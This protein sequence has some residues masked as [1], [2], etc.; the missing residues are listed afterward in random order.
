M[1]FRSS[2]CSVMFKYVFWF[3]WILYAA[4]SMSHKFETVPIRF[5]WKSKDFVCVCVSLS[6]EIVC[7]SVSSTAFQ[8]YALSNREYIIG[9]L[10]IA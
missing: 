2:K 9:F 8:S 6:L 5:G 1:L 10:A 4:K 7:A 3:D